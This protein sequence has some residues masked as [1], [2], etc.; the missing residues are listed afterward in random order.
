MAVATSYGTITIVDITDIGELSVYPSCNVP[1]TQL[2]DPNSGGYEP[3]WTSSNPAELTPVVFYAGSTLT[4]NELSTITWHRGIGANKGDPIKGN[5]ETGY[6]VNEY[7]DDT[8]KKL[9]IKT[10]I[11]GTISSRSLSYTVH[12]EY[13]VD[14]HTLTAEGQIDFN[15]LYQGSSAK[16]AKILGDNFFSLDW[17]GNTKVQNASITLEL[18]TSSNISAGYTYSDE[19][20]ATIW[21][22]Y[23]SGNTSHGTHWIPFAA[24][25]QVNPVTFNYSDLSTLFSDDQL[26]IRARTNDASIVDLTTINLLRDGAPG[27]NAISGTLSNSDQMIPVT[28]TDGQET[29]DYSTAITQATILKAS[30][31]GTVDDTST[32]TIKITP[33]NGVT[34]QHSTNGTSWTQNYSTEQTGTGKYARVTAMTGDSGTLTFTCSKTGYANISLVFTVTKIRAG[35]DGQTPTIYSLNVDAAG[36]NQ[37]ATAPYSYTPNQII[38]TAY[39]HGEDSNHQV[40]TRVYTAGKIRLETKNGNNVSKINNSGTIVSNDTSVLTNTRTLTLSSSSSVDAYIKATLYNASNEILDTQTIPIVSDGDKGD[41]GLPGVGSPSV[42]LDDENETIPCNSDSYPSGVSGFSTD[43][44][45]TARQGNEL[46]LIDSITVTENSSPALS[47]FT[48]TVPA[49]GTTPAS[50]G[51]ITLNFSNQDALTENGT[52]TIRFVSNHVK[53]YQSGELRTNGTAT[54]DKV[55]SWTA[56]PAAVDARLLQIV[57]KQNVFAQENKNEILTAVAYLTEGVDNVTD[58]VNGSYLWAKYDP[59]GTGHDTDGYVALGTSSSADAYMSGTKYKQLNVKRDAVSGY[60]SFRLQLIRTVSNVTTVLAT[61]YIAFTDKFDPIQVSVH[62][63]VGTQIKNNQGQGAIY[64]R[65]TQTNVG[66]VDMVPEEIES[67]ATVPASSTNSDDYF[68]LLSQETNSYQRKATLYNCPI[69]T[70]GTAGTSS[71]PDGTGWTAVYGTCKYHWTFRDSNNKIITQNTKLPYQYASPNLN[72][73]Q[74]IY[75]DAN[76]IDGKIT[77]DV[78]VTLD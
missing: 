4:M 63:T 52:V 67:G 28:V 2:Y 3:G 48:S 78:E 72:K 55:Y 36:I 20:A 14:G 16:T 54:I 11:L 50:S 43:V 1:S 61:Q 6:N 8:T 10:N 56:Q 70:A 76:L 49:V 44:N 51:R 15:L 77:A 18:Q 31:S 9:I 13:I 41:T 42:L 29:V 23:N 26:K 37:T 7:V 35:I 62:S 38:F 57:C 24:A 46:L 33:S 12:V 39:E 30:E 58:T 32:W 22:Y 75:I 21:E 34:F 69:G 53:Y 68:V 27:S 47:H 19:S 25:K 65:V 71:D 45:F 17:Q 73:N 59:T 64:A 74:F 40:G 66:Q 5:N 60:A